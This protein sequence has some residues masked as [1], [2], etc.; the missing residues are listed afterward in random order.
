MQRPFK[1]FALVVLVKRR[2]TTIGTTSMVDQQRGSNL[3]LG[4]LED[5]RGARVALH[6]YHGDRRL[7]NSRDIE[8]EE[9]DVLGLWLA[10][11]GTVQ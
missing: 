11:V 5:N 9:M 4:T 2:E 6:K 7:H 1:N 10:N 3:R 8:E